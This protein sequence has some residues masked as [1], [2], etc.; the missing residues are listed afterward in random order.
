LYCTA[1]TVSFVSH[2]CTLKAERQEYT[3]MCILLPLDAYILK[4]FAQKPLPRR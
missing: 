2:I 3:D 4:G 1:K